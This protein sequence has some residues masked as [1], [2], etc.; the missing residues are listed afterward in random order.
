MTENLPPEA[1]RRQ[2]ESPDADFYSVP[3]FVTHIDKGAIAAVTQLYRES[4][5]PGGAVLDLMS[6]WVSHL[7]EE[8]EYSRVVG[9]GMN[10]AELAKNPRLDAYV[11]QD[12]NRDPALPFGDAEFDGCGIC[13]SIDYLIRPVEVLREVRRVLKPGSPLVVTFSNRCFPTKAVAVW[14]MTDDRGHVRL[15]K[16]YLEAA[17]F[18]DVQ[19]LDRSPKRLFS[20][21]LYAVTGRAPE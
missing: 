2:D 7:P 1:F 10:E 15:V 17:G 14:H 18:T 3:R 12:L 21:P 6:S 20:D 9:L 19:G 8:V 16:G 4:F 11:V 5:P 13:V